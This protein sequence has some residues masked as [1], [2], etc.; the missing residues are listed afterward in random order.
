MVLRIKNPDIQLRRIAYPPEQIPPSP[1]LGV[2]DGGAL[3]VEEWGRKS[4]YSSGGY[5]IRLH[6]V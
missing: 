5:A 2:I 3:L 1:S 6:G 4:G